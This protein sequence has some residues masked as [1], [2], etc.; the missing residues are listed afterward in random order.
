MIITMTLNP[1]LDKTIE[2]PDF[3]VGAVNRV[4]SVRLDAG[5]KGINV[6]KAVRGLGSPCAAMGFLSGRSGDFIVQSLEDAGI[7]CDFVRTPG[8]TRTNT[9]IVDPVRRTN[10]DINEPG[11]EAPPADIERLR[12]RLIRRVRPGD[13]VVFSGSVPPNVDRD[14][15]RK[16]IALVKAAGAE[17]ILDADGELLR[18]G[19]GA[20]PTA[21]KPNIHELEMYCGRPLDSSEEIRG[22]ASQLLENGIDTVLVSMGEKGALLVNGCRPIFAPALEVPVRSTVGAGDAMVAA[23]AVARQNGDYPEDMLRLAVACG[24]A[25]VMAEGTQ[26][27]SPET[28]RRLFSEIRIE[29][30]E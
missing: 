15:Y 7:V 13:I 2:V 5:G 28:V 26:A 20:G 1:A 23:L 11:P 29:F 21:V 19:I 18:N 27:P 9:K 17:T 6:A 10:T 22:A 14:I 24:T 25:A 12:E 8:E 4:K 3:S 30:P 16:W